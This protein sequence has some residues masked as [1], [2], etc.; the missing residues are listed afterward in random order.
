M[1]VNVSN[2]FI[3]YKFELSP[4]SH[5][6]LVFNVSCLKKFIGTNIR[7]EIVLLELDNEGSIIFKPTTILNRITLQLRSRSITKVLIQWHGMQPKDAT[8]EPLLQIR[9]QFP[10]LNL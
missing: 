1:V 6:H 8:W 9:Q 3:A 2:R 10:H 4:S 7:A 5:S